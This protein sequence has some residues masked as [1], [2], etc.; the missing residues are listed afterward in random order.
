VRVRS[1]L[2][3]RRVVV[4][5]LAAVL[6]WGSAAHPTAAQESTIKIGVLLPLTGPAGVI[7][8]EVLHGYQLVMDSLHNTVAGKTVVSVIVDDQNSPTV[9][10]NEARRLVETEKV[11][12]FVGNLN[13]PIALALSAYALRMKVPYVTGST[14]SDITGSK[15]NFYTFRGSAEAFQFQVPLAAFLVKRGY[16]SAILMG[17]DYV[18]G[19]DTIEGTARFYISDGGSVVKKVFPRL[20]ESDYSPYF[21][22]LASQKAD[23]LFGYFFGGDSLRFARAYRAS[24]LKF[25]LSMIGSSLSVGTVAQQLGADVEGITTNEAWIWTLPDGDTKRFIDAYTAK[26]GQRPGTLAPLGYVEASILVEAIR[27]L[28][29]NVS[30][31]TALARAMEKVNFPQPGGQPFHFDENHNPYISEFFV[32]WHWQ[33]G[34]AVP[35]VIDTMRNVKQPAAAM[36]APSN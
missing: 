1:V 3:V 27:A 23:V 4:L 36:A 16:K 6:L 24:G 33:N 26:F 25:P 14:A 34:T 7:G 10:L 5:A 2:A 15:K 29:G 30:D 22:D 17:S 32:Q 31:G 28:K 35:Q 11:A 19:H 12:A 20:G 21:A 8:N 13:G 18:T 9:A